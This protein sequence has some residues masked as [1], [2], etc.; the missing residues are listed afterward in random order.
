MDPN[1]HMAKWFQFETDV[2][3][4]TEML[5][6]N[7]LLIEWINNP[8]IDQCKIAIEQTPYA[9]CLI[10]NLEVLEDFIKSQKTKKAY[11]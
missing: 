7:G 9:V 6:Q 3:Y 2:D 1:D 10:E 4:Q 8:S 11:L 5:R